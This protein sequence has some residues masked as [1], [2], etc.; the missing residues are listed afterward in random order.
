MA[1]LRKYATATDIY[2]PLIARGLVDFITSSP[3]FATGDSKVSIDGGAF[4]N[5]TNLPT[6]IGQ[7][8]CKLSL[9][10]GSLT[11]KKIMITVIDTVTKIWEDQAIIIETYSGASAEFVEDF[12]TASV[13]PTVAGRTLDV[14]TGGE[15][16][17][18]WANIGSPTT[19]NN[20]SATTIKTATDL[21]SKIDII[22][23]NVDTLI[24]KL[25]D[26]LSLANINGEVVDV[27]FVDVVA[28]L[29]AITPT[30]TTIAKMLQLLHMALR[31]Q[32]TTSTSETKIRN[33][34]GT[35]IAT[36]PVSDVSNL[37]TKDKFV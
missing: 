36:A 10:S 27:L 7:G 18:D 1:E 16:G 20:L 24:T 6:Y 17:L 9:T 5:T 12:S 19:V 30:T 26:V 32:T 13:K 29:I 22:D 25:P 35:V 37:Y 11:G 28:E 15:A 3:T 34:A 31:N 8:M 33:N 23:T 2:F 4:A 14:T 21:E